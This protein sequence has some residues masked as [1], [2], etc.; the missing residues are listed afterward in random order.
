MDS[1]PSPPPPPPSLTPPPSSPFS[2]AAPVPAPVPPK[3][4]G[5]KC[6]LFGCG[7]C[8]GLLVL[9]VLASI[10]I[11]LFAMNVIKKTDVYAEAFRRVQNSTEVQEALGTPIDNGW[12]FSGTVNYNNGEGKAAFTVPVTGPKGEAT[13]R[14][15]AEKSSD[16]EWKYSTLDVEFP[17]GHKVDL[18]GTP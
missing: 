16:S 1:F 18:R 3:N 4:S 5:G 10:G 9:G 7:G 2:N 6:A 14:V 13:M 15:V 11:F 17:D 8:L 12:A